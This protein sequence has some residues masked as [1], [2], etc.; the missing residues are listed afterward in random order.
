M[1]V[2]RAAKMPTVTE[3][4]ATAKK[5]QAAHVALAGSS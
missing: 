3:V 5:L 4:V 2:E 1:L